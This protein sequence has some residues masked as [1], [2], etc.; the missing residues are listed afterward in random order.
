MK[1]GR[2]VCVC[3]CSSVSTDVK[4]MYEVRVVCTNGFM[5][6]VLMF[7]CSFPP[8]P[9]LPALP[10]PRPSPLFSSPPFPGNGSHVL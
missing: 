6:I 9:P 5:L 8:L 10:L 7:T 1:E 4:Y 3:S 2:G